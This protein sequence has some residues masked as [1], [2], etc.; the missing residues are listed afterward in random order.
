MLY[1]LHIWLLNLLL[2][3][4]LVLLVLNLLI[5]L[6]LLLL[7]WLDLWQLLLNLRHPMLYCCINACAYLRLSAS[8]VQQL[9][10]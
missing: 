4:L 10:L 6:L 1:G 3:L 2:L 5:H 8:P 9:L 7:L